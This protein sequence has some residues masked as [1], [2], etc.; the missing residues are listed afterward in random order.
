MSALDDRPDQALV[1]QFAGD[2]LDADR[3]TMHSDVYM[4]LMGATLGGPGAM[5]ISGTGAMAIALDGAGRVHT[6]A[7]WGYLLDDPGSAYA[8]AVQ[9]LRAALSAWEGVG[10]ATALC[11]RALQFFGTPD[12]RALIASIYQPP[13]EPA[14]IAQFARAVL[15]A[16]AEGDAVAAGLVDRNM[17][18]LAGQAARLA[19]LCPPGAGVY[20]YGGMFEHN[21]WVTGLFG[22][23]L[24]ALRPGAKT[25]RPEFPPEIGAV[26]SHLKQAGGLTGGVVAN[27]RRTWRRNAV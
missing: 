21:A 19:A 12:E 25:L 20:L 27:L 5:V 4:A 9:A 3:L 14:R 2:L 26:I 16:A 24:A 15:S 23:K 8:V 10:E 1:R 7:G 22:E 18:Y 6:R 11:D 13:V 17:A